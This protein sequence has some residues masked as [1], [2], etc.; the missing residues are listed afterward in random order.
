[1]PDLVYFAYRTPNS[2][3]AP[4]LSDVQTKGWRPEPLNRRFQRSHHSLTGQRVAHFHRHAFRVWSW[5][6]LTL[7][8]FVRWPPDH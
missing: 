4:I 3:R 8:L 5:T 2:M 6:T 7:E 1:V